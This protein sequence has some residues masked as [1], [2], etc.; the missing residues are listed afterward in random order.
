[1]SFYKRTNLL[2]PDYGEPYTHFLRHDNSFVLSIPVRYHKHGRILKTF[3]GY[4][5]VIPE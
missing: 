2:S 5:N 4:I 3:R 1:M